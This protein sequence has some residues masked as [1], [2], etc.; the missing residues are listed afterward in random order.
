[1]KIHLT[2]VFAAQWAAQSARQTIVDQLKRKINQK[3][4]FFPTFYTIHIKIWK[5]KKNL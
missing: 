2:A 1:M 3:N 4:K 5:G